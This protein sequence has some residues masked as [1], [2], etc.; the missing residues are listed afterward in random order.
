MPVHSAA[1]KIYNIDAGTVGATAVYAGAVKVYPEAKATVKTQPASVSADEGTNFTM[2]AAFNAGFSGATYTHIWQELLVGGSWVTIGG[3]TTLTLTHGST[4]ARNGAKYR[5]RARDKYGQ[6]TW[7]NAAATLTAT[8]PA[9]DLIETAL[10]LGPTEFWYNNTNTTTSNAGKVRGV[11]LEVRNFVPPG[12]GPSI[13][14]Y[15]S[16]NFTPATNEWS[17]TN[18][19]AQ[20]TIT[21][22]EA[23][24]GFLYFRTGATLPANGTWLASFSDYATRPYAWEITFSNDFSG[25]VAMR[26]SAGTSSYN[27]GAALAPN[28]NYFLSFSMPTPGGFGVPFNLFVNGVKYETPNLYP[29][30]LPTSQCNIALGGFGSNSPNRASFYAGP[31]GV[32]NKILTDAQ[33]MEL[34][35][36]SQVAP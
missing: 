26:M 35:N 23:Q 12:A 2:T 22:S 14:G 16:D 8:V 36:A 18:I 9:Q 7:T 29:P 33:H 30:V 20:P 11:L 10:A 31:F 25:R 3:Q 19:T 34:W 13:N 21:E 5:C 6:N 1:T 27:Y 4:A 24:S 28:T 17:R 15:A 32:Y